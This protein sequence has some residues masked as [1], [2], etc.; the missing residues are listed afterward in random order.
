M[1]S[2][3]CENDCYQEVVHWYNVIPQDDILNLTALSNKIYSYEVQ[4]KA[5]DAAP[6]SLR[7]H[8]TLWDLQEYFKQFIK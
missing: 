2:S 6:L 3:E 8:L 7:T 4:L 5:I 1:M